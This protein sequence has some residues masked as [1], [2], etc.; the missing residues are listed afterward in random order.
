[1]GAGSSTCI[2]TDTTAL[3][4]GKTL[5]SAANWSNIAYGNGKFI[6][7]AKGS[8]TA[9]LSS[10]AGNSWS[11]VTLPSVADWSAVTYGGGIVT[12]KQIGRAHV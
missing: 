11:S 10:D 6:V 1:M 3:W 2:T 7:V 8:S 9:A 4:V 5:P 12:G